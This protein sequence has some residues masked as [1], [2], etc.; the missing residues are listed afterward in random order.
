MGIEC[1]SENQTDSGNAAGVLGIEYMAAAQA[2]DFRNVPSNRHPK[3]A[4]YDSRQSE[5]LEEDR[6][7]FDDTIKWLN[8]E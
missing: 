5:H 1:R 7:L 4:R 3:H 6:A 8:W 2:L